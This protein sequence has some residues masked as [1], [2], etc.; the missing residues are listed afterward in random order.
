MA[1]N[2]WYQVYSNARVRD[3]AVNW[4]P[5]PCLFSPVRG[6]G[7]REKRKPGVWYAFQL[8][9]NNWMRNMISL[10]RFLEIIQE[11]KLGGESVEDVSS[12]TPYT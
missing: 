5:Q 4:S 9:G 1:L 11:T 10:A 7:L 6:L 12:R 8:P 2:Q 3:A